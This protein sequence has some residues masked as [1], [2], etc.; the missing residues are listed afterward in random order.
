VRELARV[1]AERTRAFLRELSRAAREPTRLYL[2]GG[3]TAVLLGWRASTA[4]IDMVLSPDRDEL[5]RAIPRLKEELQV[6]VELACPAH[7]IPALPGWEDRSLFELREGSLDVLHYDPYAQAL[8]KIERG[9]P[10]DDDDVRA[11]IA[12]GLVEPARARALYLAIEP[13][14][15]RFPSIDPRRF[16]RRVEELF[17]ALP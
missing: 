1:D 6:N 4:D 15:Y 16:R 17:G 14:L 7:F 2:T 12:H 13:E 11:F 5:L 9:F 3:A 8:S 10:H